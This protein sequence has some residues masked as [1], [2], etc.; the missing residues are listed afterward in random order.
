MLSHCAARREGRKTQESHNEKEKSVTDRY[1]NY[2]STYCDILNTKAN[3][4]DLHDKENG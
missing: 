4:Q 1:R 3:S 2:S